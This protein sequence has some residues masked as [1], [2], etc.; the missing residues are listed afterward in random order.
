MDTFKEKYIKYKIKY[1][2]LKEQVGSAAII[3]PYCNNKILPT[4]ALEHIRIEHNIIL[5][6]EQFNE[7]VKARA[8][9]AKAPGGKY[10]I[11][12]K[13]CDKIVSSKGILSFHI[14]SKH[15]DSITEDDFNLIDNYI[16]DKE[17]TKSL[18]SRKKFVELEIRFNK[19]IFLPGMDKEMLADND[20]IISRRK[21][22]LNRNNRHAK[23]Y[24][25]PNDQFEQLEAIAA[26][27]LPQLEFS[28]EETDDAGPAAAAAYPVPAAAAAYPAAAAGTS[29]FELNNIP[30]DLLFEPSDFLPIAYESENMKCIYCGLSFN[31]YKLAKHLLA[32]HHPV[33]NMNDLEFIKSVIPAGGP[34]QLRISNIILKIQRKIIERDEQ[35]Q[36]IQFRLPNIDLTNNDDVLENQFSENLFPD[37]FPPPQSPLLPVEA[38]ENKEFNDYLDYLLTETPEDI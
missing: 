31:R 27:L 35:T 20:E 24:V 12:C 4:K 28:D 21:V 13:Y 14:L 38:T 5:T 9:A 30:I 16:S 26:N 29:D 1:N 34:H 10:S 15:F 11:K 6:Q 17:L 8:K 22:R 18:I 23:R 25:E 19:I 3:C 32:R 7:I 37:V 36:N 33:I 2:Q